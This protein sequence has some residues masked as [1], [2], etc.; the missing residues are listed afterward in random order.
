MACTCTRHVTSST[1]L[2]KNTTPSRSPQNHPQKA[3]E[4]E[5]LTI[6]RIVGKLLAMHEHHDA[7]RVNWQELLLLERLVQL[8]LGNVLE[9]GLGG[10]QQS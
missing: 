3:K 2:P 5:E 7:K 6:S 8:L 9:V 1:K 10:D 4:K